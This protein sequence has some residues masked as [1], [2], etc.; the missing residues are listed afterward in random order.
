MGLMGLYMGKVKRVPKKM[1]QWLFGKSPKGVG[2]LF[3]IA[4][5]ERVQLSF[6]SL[7]LNRKMWRPSD[8]KLIILITEEKFGSKKKRAALML[9]KSQ[10]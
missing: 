3:M 1:V 9:F 8:F 2:F 5:F 4:S 7:Q 6:I 10:K